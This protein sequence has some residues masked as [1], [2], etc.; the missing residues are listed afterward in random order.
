MSSKRPGGQGKSKRDKIDTQDEVVVDGV[1]VLGTL[2]TDPI[3]T[4]FVNK[5]HLGEIKSGLDEVV[6]K[7]SQR[8][9]A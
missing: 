4:V 1:E 5:A 7:V 8:L 9:M 2:K 6:K 3:P